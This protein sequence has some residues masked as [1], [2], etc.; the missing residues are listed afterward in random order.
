MEAIA[1]S[2]SLK[3]QNRHAIFSKLAEI[4]TLQNISVVI[5]GNLPR[6]EVLRRHLPTDLVDKLDELF[7]IQLNMWNAKVLR[8]DMG[9]I[10]TRLNAEVFVIGQVKG[11]VEEEINIY[12]SKG[13]KINYISI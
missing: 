2:F 12:T 8:Q 13:L 11:G 10:A 7:P 1:I 5:H 9:E 3:D 4:A 6:Q